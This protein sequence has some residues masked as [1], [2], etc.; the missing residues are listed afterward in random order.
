MELDARSDAQEMVRSIIN[1]ASSAMTISPAV[2]ISRYYRSLD[3]MIRMA[4]VYASD[5]DEVSALK[6]YVR[7][8]R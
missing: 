1:D 3:E 5:H 4:T 6:L 8:C 7:F 2:P